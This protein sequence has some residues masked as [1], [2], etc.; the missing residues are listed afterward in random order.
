MYVK[1]VWRKRSIQFF[2]IVHIGLCVGIVHMNRSYKV[3]IKCI[4]VL[5]VEQRFFKSSEH[6]IPDKMKIITK[7]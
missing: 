4:N 5:F 1:Y 7:L 6:L 2:W 3:S